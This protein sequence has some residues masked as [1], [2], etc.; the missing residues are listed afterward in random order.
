MSLLQLEHRGTKLNGSL[1]PPLE[2]LCIC[3][4]SQDRIFVL[5]R[6]VRI[7]PMHTHV[8]LLP[9]QSSHAFARC[10]FETRAIRI[11]LADGVAIARLDSRGSCSFLFMSEIY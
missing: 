9:I 10:F 4:T 8:C 2:E 6:V 11:G 3:D 5:S 1:D 7:Q